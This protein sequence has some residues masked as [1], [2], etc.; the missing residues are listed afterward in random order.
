VCLI[1]LGVKKTDDPSLSDGCRKRHD[2]AAVYFLSNFVFPIP[3]VIAF[4]S[5]MSRGG[6]IY[7]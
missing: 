6:V 4:V 1:G 3:Y 2:D 7:D 5:E